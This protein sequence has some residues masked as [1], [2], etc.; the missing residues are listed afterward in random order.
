MRAF[1]QVAVPWQSGPL[2]STWARSLPRRLTETERTCSHLSAGSNPVG[3]AADL[4]VVQRT[5]LSHRARST[6]VVPEPVLTN[7]A[8]LPLLIG[9]F[10]F[11]ALSAVIL[12]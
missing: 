9:L 2:R 11:A 10:G 4:D 7:K 8:S 5:D 6:E 1:P 12:N 3:T